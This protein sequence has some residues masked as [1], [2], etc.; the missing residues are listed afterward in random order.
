MGI[1]AQVIVTGVVT[2]SFYALVAAAMQLVYDSA[3]ILN[4]GQGGLVVSGMFAMWWLNTSR[5]VDPWLSLLLL[6][7][8]GAALGALFY[9]VVVRP[10][11]DRHHIQVAIATL[12]GGSIFVGLYAKLFGSSVKVVDPFLSGGSIHV[13]SVTI[14]PQSIVVVIG[15]TLIVLALAAFFRF[16]WTG[17]AMRANAENREGVRVVGASP[18]RIN[19]ATFVVSGTVSALAGGLIVPILGARFDFGNNLVLVAFVSA[20]LGGLT[21]TMGSAFGGLA[22]GLSSAAIAAIF[23]SDFQYFWLLAV[24][25][26]LILFRPNGVFGRHVQEE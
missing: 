6:I 5:G 21:S 1:V 14:T 17:L 2:G 20:V 16:T 18:S 13:G 24:V 23:G 3:R 10:L 19:L 7:P 8:I 9:L 22:V 12:A 11:E 25:L 26:P 15:S 4:F